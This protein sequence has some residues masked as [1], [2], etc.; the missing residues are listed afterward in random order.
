MEKIAK[1]DD[2]TSFGPNIKGYTDVTSAG[3]CA[4]DIEP[5]ESSVSD[6]GPV[7]A[8]AVAD[9]GYPVATAV[10]GTILVPLHNHARFIAA[11]LDG[12]VAAW[13]PG[14]ELLLI[15][16]ASVDDGFAIAGRILANHPWIPVTMLRTSETL[17]HGNAQTIVRL[18]NGRFIIQ[19]DSDD[20]PMPDR[21]TA[22][23]ECFASDP[24]CRL[25]TSN[26]MT[27]SEDGLPIG[28]F[29]THWPDET[30]HDPVFAAGRSYDTRWLGATA[31]YHRDVFDLFPPLDAELCPYG[32][33]LL[34]PLRAL[35]LGTHRYIARPL[36]AYRMHASNAHRV[37]GAYAEAPAARERYEALRMTVLAQKLRDIE[38]PITGGA[39]DKVRLSEE[40]RRVFFETFDRWSRAMVRATRE[41]PPAPGKPFLPAVPPI[42]TLRTG[43]MLSLAASSPFAAIAEQWSGVHRAEDW[44]CWLGRVALVA[45]RVAGRNGG[46]IALDLHTTPFKDLNRFSVRV[47]SEPWTELALG[48]VECRQ[49]VLT[50]PPSESD[51][52]IVPLIILSHD[53]AAP[54]S[55]GETATDDR[56][57]GVGLRTLHLM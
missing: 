32:L 5:Q 8:G 14:F 15:D 46:R 27:I 25:V 4:L 19:C 17:G 52:Q 31:A 51:V 33:D 41:P 43:Q 28:L 49:V 12:V 2:V 56:L 54:Q 48:P 11:C 13:R 34:T 37:A 45:L 47:G 35:L 23:V 36:V 53:A 6:E 44:G 9:V 1:I 26:A 3:P 39:H 10:V 29:D 22:I 40:G 38:V 24:D 18:A 57:L 16:D 30:F 20:V 50:V 7:A 55:N 21:F 42:A